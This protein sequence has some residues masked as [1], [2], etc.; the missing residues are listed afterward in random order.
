MVYYSKMFVLIKGIKY[1]IKYMT[2]S[3][4]EKKFGRTCDANFSGSKRELTFKSDQ[5]KKDTIMHEVIHAFYDSLLLNSCHNIDIE[6]QEEIFCELIST[7]YTDIG[8]ITNNIYKYLK[9][10]NAKN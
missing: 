4:Y 5:I 8:K 6:D 7:H 9:E 1:S 2:K 10:Q 3:D